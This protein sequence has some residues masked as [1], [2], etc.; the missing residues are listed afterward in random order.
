MRCLLL[1]LIAEMPR[2]SLRKAVLDELEELHLRR[3]VKKLLELVT[4][5]DSNDED[6]VEQVLGMAI[7]GAYKDT[8]NKRYIAHQGYWNGAEQGVFQRELYED[9]TG[10][11]L[12][13]NNYSSR[14]LIL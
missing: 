14:T 5:E 8:L 7:E 10:E 13:Q 6:T 2:K 3:Q 4:D 11:Q 9:E 1:L 12:T